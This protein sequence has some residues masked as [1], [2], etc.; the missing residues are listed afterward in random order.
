MIKRRPINKAPLG[1]KGFTSDSFQN[2][3]A[4]LGYGAQNV[5]SGSSYGFNPISRNHT[6]LEWMYRGSWLVKVIIDSVADDMTREG[7]T[8]ETDMSPDDMSKFERYLDRKMMWQQLNETIKWSRLYG[9]CIAVIM[10]AGQKLDTPL[11]L[12]TIGKDQF[13]GLMVL[14]RWVLWPHLEDPVTDIGIDF[15]L[16]KFYDI[17]SDARAMPQA[18][19]HHTR[20]IRIEGATL[21]YWQKMAENMWGLSILEPLFDRLIAFDSTTQGAAQLVYRAHLRTLKIEKLRELIAFGGEAYQGVLQ[22]LQMIRLM[23]TNE[24]LTVIDSTDEFDTHQYAFGG[25]S[26]VLIQFAQQ[27]SG[28]AQIP[29]VRL[30][31]QSPAGLNATGDAD[32]RNYYDAIN[33]QQ[34][35]RLRRPVATILEVAYRS[36]FG[37][38][39]P[40]DFDFS[41]NPL[42]Q[43]TDAEKAAI[44]LNITNTVSVASQDGLISTAIALKE[45]K[46]SAKI[47][48]IWSNISDEDITEAEEMLPSIGEQGQMENELAMMQATKPAAGPG[49]PGEGGENGG[50]AEAGK[51]AQG[52][53]K[54]PA[55]PV[56]AVMGTKQDVKAHY[57]KDGGELEAPERRK[58]SPLYVKPDETSPLITDSLP[59]RDIHGI[60]VVI[61][62]PKDTRRQGNGW[63]AQMPADYGYVSG[64][65]S[66][67]GDN[68][69]LDVFVGPDKESEAV[70]IINQQNPDTQQ[71][72]EF[73]VILCA[74][75]KED[76][77][78]IY[79]AAFPDGRG[80]ERIGGMKR[81]NISG[82]KQFISE[83]P[84]GGAK[85]VNGTHSLGT[86]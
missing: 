35:S 51:P 4:S 41:F 53:F 38:K 65:S 64:T 47:T 80:P 40:E 1:G 57:A 24:G 15:G 22:Q 17:V 81:T 26:D 45:L 66:P 10:I 77:M 6:M 75:S 63:S 29:L 9:G 70:W 73:K 36:F 52:A 33:A 78:N 48:G 84:Y 39:P 58:M 3:A 19:I 82:L 62:T 83:W 20:C 11:R 49:K 34:E 54:T 59:M 25:L 12:D 2:F 32:I 30:F 42:W 5:S 61:E 16:P 72:D 14:D 67:E 71:F 37:K 55:S 18:K 46:Q 76:A 74:S 27:L 85:Y 68:E 56:A 28:A 43:M 13:E 50:G 69:Q 86:A 7:V 31:G 79:I 60:P 8:L 23:Q 21:P 44:A